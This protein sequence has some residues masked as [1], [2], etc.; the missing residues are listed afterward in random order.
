MQVRCK[1]HQFHLWCR[2]IPRRRAQ[3]PTPVSLPGESHG[4]RSLAGYRPWGHT[5]LNMTKATQYTQPFAVMV[6]RQ[7]WKKPLASQYTSKQSHKLWLKIILQTSVSYFPCCKLFYKNSSFIG[8]FQMTS[9]G[10]YKSSIGLRK[11]NPLA[12]RQTYGF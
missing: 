1:R 10:C 8:I 9:T 5:E 7:W 2:K 3:Q 6:Q 4:Q 11:K 12:D